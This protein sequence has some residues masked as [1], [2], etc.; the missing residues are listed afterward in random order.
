[1]LILVYLATFVLYRRCKVIDSIILY[2]CNVAETT[3]MKT[4]GTRLQCEPSTMVVEG[5]FVT[6]LPIL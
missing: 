3:F 1:M 5:K 6:I 2:I 4:P